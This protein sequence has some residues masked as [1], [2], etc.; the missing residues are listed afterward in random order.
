MDYNYT[1][2]MDA[3]KPLNRF[4]NISKSELVDIK[5][6]AMSHVMFKIGKWLSGYIINEQRA[7]HAALPRDLHRRAD[8]NQGIDYHFFKSQVF[9]VH[10]E[11][12]RVISIWVSIK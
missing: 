9:A 3:E 10:T 5:M 2:R 7:I 1:F 12:S 8:S 6:Q 11:T 4:Q